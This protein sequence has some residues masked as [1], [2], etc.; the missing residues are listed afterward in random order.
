ML[1]AVND[2]AETPLRGRRR[3]KRQRVQDHVPTQRGRGVGLGTYELTG[4]GCSLAGTYKWNNNAYGEFANGLGEDV[5]TQKLKLSRGIQENLERPKLEPPLNF[6]A[7][8]SYFTGE[9]SMT[10]EEELQVKE[11]FPGREGLHEMFTS[12][13]TTPTAP[14]NWYVGAQPGAKLVAAQAAKLNLASESLTFNTTIAGLPTKF[15]ASGIECPNCKIENQAGT[16]ENKGNTEAVFSGE[17]TLTGLKVVEPSGCSMA[18]TLKM[19]PLIGV[20]GGEKGSSRKAM[21]R[22]GPSTGLAWS[23]GAG[24]ELAGSQCPRANTY[25]LTG[26]EFGEFINPL[27]AD[28]KSQRFRFSQTLQELL[29]EPSS[30]RFGANPLIVTGEINLSPE[31]EFQIKEK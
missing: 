28:A 16:G 8:Y 17:P 23:A 19:K 4:Y 2:K 18:S 22:L 12:P 30:M 27:E 15:T 9:I 10:A 5:R 7:N 1:H 11:S 21:V 3:R 26:S 24:I 6:G 13:S 25:K 29:G 20:V 31:V 14:R